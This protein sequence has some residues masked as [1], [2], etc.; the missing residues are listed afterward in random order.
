MAKTRKS[1][2][3]PAKKSNTKFSKEQH[4]RLKSRKN[5]LTTKTPSHT[6][7]K[8][9]RNRVI[10]PGS[11]QEFP[12]VVLGATPHK[13]TQGVKSKYYKA[14]QTNPDSSVRA[15]RNNALGHTTAFIN[16]PNSRY[17]NGKKIA[18]TT[19]KRDL[20][21]VIPGKKFNYENPIGTFTSR[22]YEIGKATNL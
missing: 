22:A 9:K 20:L 4:D 12:T 18:N 1:K 3:F 21:T 6:R 11:G 7:S 14:A 5:P 19:S 8:G 17:P 15:N 16:S 10:L 2:S 13:S